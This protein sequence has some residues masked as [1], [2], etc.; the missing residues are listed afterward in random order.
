VLLGIAYY[1]AGVPHPTLLGAVTGIAATVPFAAVAVLAAIGLVMLAAGSVSAAI[2]VVAFGYLVIFVADH[3]VRPV[4]IGGATRLPFL[5][6]LLG[7]LG[8][9]ET[10][11]LLGL[12]LGPALMAAVMLIWRDWTNPDGAAPG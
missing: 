2:A 5:W 6:V 8:G 12:F 3:F 9:V 7:I 10:W 4:L 1:L 11:G